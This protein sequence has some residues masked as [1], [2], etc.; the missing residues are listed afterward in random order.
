MSKTRFI[1]LCRKA[2]DFKENI[3]R[4]AI[5]ICNLIEQNSNEPPKTLELPIKE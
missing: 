2:H 5:E 3:H 1:S 4:A